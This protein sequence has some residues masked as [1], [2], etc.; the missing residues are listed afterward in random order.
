MCVCEAGYS[1][2]D[3]AIGLLCVLACIGLEILA[4]EVWKDLVGTVYEA[5]KKKLG[6]FKMGLAICDIANA[7]QN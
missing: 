7:K 4:S 3:A 5:G 1:S 2:Q 6:I